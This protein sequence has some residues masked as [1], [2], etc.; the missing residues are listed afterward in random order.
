VKGRVVF[1][2]TLSAAFVAISG[3]STLVPAKPDDLSGWQA[4]PL[5]PDPALSLAAGTSDACQSRSIL[6]DATLP[7]PFSQ[8]MEV[9]LQDQR[10]AATAGF[11][12][13]TEGY[14]GSCVLSAG[15]T[16]FGTLEDKTLTP[17]PHGV[18]I[19]GSAG[20]LI[21]ASSA[22]WVW[23]RV[24]QSIASVAIDLGPALHVVD[25]DNRVVTASVGGGYWF[26]WWPEPGIALVVTARDAQGNVVASEKLFDDG[27]V[28][29]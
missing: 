23:G 10:T 12:V 22:S 16:S 5:L 20:G 19:D 8:P 6:L 15:G 21:G 26:G 18:T 29:Q 27:W 11:I 28:A 17:I 2:M 13:R 9:V 1:G 7:P 4:T 24:D 3:C 14:I 25:D